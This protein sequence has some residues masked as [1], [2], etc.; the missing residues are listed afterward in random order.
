MVAIFLS[1]FDVHVQRAPVAGTIKGVKY[2]TGKFFD[3]RHPDASEMNEYRLIDMETA[4]GA[5][6]RETDCRAD[7]GACRLGGKAR[8]GERAGSMIVLVARGDFSADSTDRG[9][10][11]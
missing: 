1:V 7:C 10:S 4:D 2:E 11:W 8:R 9:R 5:G 3:V 6:K